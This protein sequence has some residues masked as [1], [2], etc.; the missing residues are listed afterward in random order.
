VI[1]LVGEDFVLPG[2]GETL[3]ALEQRVMAQELEEL[4]SSW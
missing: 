4:S 1:E 2:R 3:G